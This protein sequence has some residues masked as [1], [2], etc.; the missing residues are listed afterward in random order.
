MPELQD[1][2]VKLPAQ[3]ELEELKRRQSKRRL[4]EDTQIKQPELAELKKKQSR[5]KLSKEKISARDLRIFKRRLILNELGP[6]E[7]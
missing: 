1:V 5:R 3:P 7:N 6:W 2:Q 4:S